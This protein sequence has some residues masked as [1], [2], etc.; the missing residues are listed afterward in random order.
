[1]AT[2]IAHLRLTENLIDYIKTYYQRG[3]QKARAFERPDVYLSQVERTV[4]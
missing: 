2:W 1:M 3:D 4:W